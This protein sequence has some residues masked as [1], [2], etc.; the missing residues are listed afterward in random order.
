VPWAPIPACR[1]GSSR[2][3]GAEVEGLAEVLGAVARL[4]RVD[5]HAADR[6][7]G[8]FWRERRAI[9][10]RRLRVPRDGGALWGCLARRHVPIPFVRPLH[11]ARS[12]TP[13]KGPHPER[14]G[15]AFHRGSRLRLAAH[16]SI[17]I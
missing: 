3:L 6:V 15:V 10:R 9:W 2:A 8:A 12:P 1:P 14:R 17:S 4:R 5:G 16:V 7:D 13:Y 11:A